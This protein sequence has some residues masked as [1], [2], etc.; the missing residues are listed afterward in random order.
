MSF[1]GPGSA[2]SFAAPTRPSRRVGSYSSSVGGGNSSST[3]T[4]PST[5]TGPAPVDP[6][7]NPSHGSWSNAAASPRQREDSANSG[8]SGPRSFSSILSPSLTANGINGDGDYT[9]GGGGGGYVGGSK[10]GAKPFV[11]SRDFLLS[12]Y[13]D[14]KAKKRPLELAVHEMATR[15]L[16]ASDEAEYKP[17]ALQDYRDGEKDV[18]L[19][20]PLPALTQQLTRNCACSALFYFD[21]SRQRS[22]FSYEPKRIACTFEQRRRSFE[23]Y[24]RS[25]DSRYPPS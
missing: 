9:N 24:S 1:G 2:F 5:H 19:T 20:I 17:W 22:P 25:L 23:R 8:D 13:D 21:P 10:G 4:S 18:S 15:D 11:Y 3:A 7:A 12:L 16:S 6:P 14:E